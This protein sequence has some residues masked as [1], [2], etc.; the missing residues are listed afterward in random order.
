M[1]S[2]RI[3]T[4]GNTNKTSLTSRPSPEPLTLVDIMPLLQLAKIQDVASQQ[5]VPQFAPTSFSSYALPPLLA[6]AKATDNA[7]IPSDVAGALAA[8]RARALAFANRA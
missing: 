4:R 8:A 5:Q 1:V 6:L 3:S 7:E 2:V